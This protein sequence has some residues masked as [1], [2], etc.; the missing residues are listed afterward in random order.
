LLL[1]SYDDLGTIN[2]GTGSD[3]T[4]RELAELIRDVVGYTGDITYDT[5]K[6]DGTPQKRLDVTRLRELGWEPSTP[7]K[8][9]LEKTY[10]WFLG[11]L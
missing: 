3:I 2:V 9:G 10:S 5:S 6:P 8:S 1:D 4:I 11:E 7:L